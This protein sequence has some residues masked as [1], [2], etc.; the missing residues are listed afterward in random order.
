MEVKGWDSKGTS[1]QIEDAK[2]LYL[3]YNTTL[4]LNRIPIEWY[5]AFATNNFQL[6]LHLR[7]TDS[8]NTISPHNDNLRFP[9]RHEQHSPGRSLPQLHLCQNFLPQGICATSTAK[10]TPTPTPSSWLN[11]TA[12]PPRSSLPCPPYSPTTSPLNPT[13]S[14]PQRRLY[15]HGQ[16][17]SP[18]Q[19]SKPSA[20]SAPCRL[21]GEG[22]AVLSP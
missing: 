17:S 4:A 5:P 8:T 21:T 11:L 7:K 9:L 10:G 22:T 1:G 20:P 3:Y 15:G 18:S 13:N 19:A 12:P 6:N 16:C 2:I 14:S